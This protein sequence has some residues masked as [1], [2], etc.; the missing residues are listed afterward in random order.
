MKPSL[1]E[2]LHA[3]R[4][5]GGAPPFDDAHRVALVA[6]GGA[7]RGVIAGGMVSAIEEA[8]FTNCFDLMIGTSAG[9]CA[10]AYL[11]AGQARYGTRIFYEDI[12]NHSFI[13][14]RRA[15]CGRAV[16]DI[17][18]L[19]DHVFQKA[20][21][22]DCTRLCAP[23]ARLIAIATDVDK[24]EGV[25]LEGFETPG[26]AYE[27]LRAATRMPIFAAGP[28]EIDGR[29]YIDG[30]AAD[31]I[32][33]DHARRLGATHILVML[34]R[35]T[36]SMVSSQPSHIRDY[37]KSSLYAA[38]Y[39]WKLQTVSRREAKQYR[40]MYCLLASGIY[41]HDGVPYYGVAPAGEFQ[42]VSKTEMSEQI[43]RSAARHGLHRMR[44]FLSVERNLS[45]TLRH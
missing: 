2:I 28:V 4:A 11:R 36:N 24:G 10:L 43:L 34:T 16:V 17:D 15:L 32:P 41:Q 31:R 7:M 33:I 6:E 30:A 20:K 40:K 29:R 37:F 19:V 45:T 44:R 39:H 22:L 21:P 18:F 3:R 38:F 9:V 5:V 26:K 27:I 35:S 23:G 25:A 1:L 8:G 42:D 13:N 12:N 14:F